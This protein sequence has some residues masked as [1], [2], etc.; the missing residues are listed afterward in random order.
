MYIYTSRVDT[1]SIIF[2]TKIDLVKWNTT[3]IYI[4]V[5]D[6]LIST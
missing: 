4:I 6:E 3:R 1:V 5:Y 2:K